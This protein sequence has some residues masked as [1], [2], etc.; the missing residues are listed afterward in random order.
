MGNN[1]TL[2][3]LEKLQKELN[4]TLSFQLSKMNDIVK[5]AE[6]L[7]EKNGRVNKKEATMVLM[8]DKSILIKFN[9]PNDG[10]NFFDDFKVK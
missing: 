10:E 3:E 5:N 1:K 9:N 4:K 2:S 6:I 8:A 7:K